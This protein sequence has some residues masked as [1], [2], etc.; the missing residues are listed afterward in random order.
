MHVDVDLAR[1]ERDEQ[2]DD[3]MA[4]ARQVVGVGGAHHADQQLVAHRA[5][6]DEEI[7]A[8]RIGAGQRRQRGK[9][10]D[11]Q[12][13]APAHHLDGVGLEL[14]T[15]NVGEPR[16]TSGRAGQGGRPGHRHALLARQREGDIRPA[17]PQPA[18]HIAD[19]LA[20]GAVGLKKLKAGRRGVEQVAH[21][22]P[23]AVA[24]RRGL[25]IGLL[26][27]VD[28]DGPGMRLAGVPGGDRKPRHR[29]D[30]RQRLAAKAQRADVV[31]IVV[32]QL[33][34]GV[35][36]DRERE[37]VARHAGAIV[38][39]ANEPAA[40][41]VG[42]DLDLAR[43]GVQRILDQLL[44][45]ARRA[46]DHFARGDA[47]DDAFGQLADGHPVFQDESGAAN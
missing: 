26:A 17:H 6:I 39:D 22:D 10:R 40:A 21:L 31:E 29:A 11:A 20:F 34:G 46:L 32:R 14:R 33:R 24:E 13:F 28:L 45:D 42:H 3:R 2:R 15:Q 30:R 25:H 19:R 5:A 43:A 41:A 23:R 16:Q 35:A 38:G 8:K 4:V 36:L 27:A 7:L 12:A 9:A 47:V 44:H 18:N 1:I 37:I